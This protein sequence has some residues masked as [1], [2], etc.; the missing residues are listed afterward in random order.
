MGLSRCYGTSFFSNL[1]SNCAGLHLSPSQPQ[2]IKLK[3]F[4]MCIVFL[5][6]IYINSIE[7]AQIILKINIAVIEAN[8]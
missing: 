3:K 2:S 1:V 8:A 5:W 4:I 7:L 6:K